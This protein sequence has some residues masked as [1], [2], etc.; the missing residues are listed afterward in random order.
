MQLLTLHV[1]IHARSMLPCQDSPSVKCTYDANIEVAKPLTAV[2]SAICKSKTEKND[3]I[4]YHFVQEI[5]I[6]SYL[7]ALAIGDIESKKIGSRSNVWAE[8]QQLEAAAFEFDETDAFL[9]AAEE[10][11][12]KYCWG[13]Y[14]LL[15]LPPS[16][17]Y[18]GFVI[19][20]TSLTIELAWKMFQW[21]LLHQHCWQETRVCQ[22][23]LHTNLHIHGGMLKNNKNC[24][25]FN[26]FHSGNLVTNLN[27]EVRFFFLK[28]SNVKRFY[29]STFG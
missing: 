22:M 14:N 3:T 27:W 13:E 23:L 18:G 28:K 17:P 25:F 8:K 4:V 2:M 12:P 20:S 26:T 5:P 29:K 15:V 6:A 1:A 24:W 11:L 7:I 16:F 19:L 9:K 10:F 21:F